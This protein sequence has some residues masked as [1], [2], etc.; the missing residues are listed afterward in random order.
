[1]KFQNVK[2]ICVVGAGAMGR[3][4][5]M[6]NALGGYDVTLNDSAGEALTKAQ[7]WAES[8]LAGRVQ[9]GRLTAEKAAEAKGKI[10]YSQD[11]T[12][13][14]SDADLVIEA[15]VELLDVKQAMFENLDAICP[16]HTIL[17]SNS[18]SYPSSQLAAFTKRPEKVCN[19][20]YFNPPTVMELVE[21]VRNEKTS[22]ETV[23]I[24]MAV[25]RQTGKGPILINKEIDGFVVNRI[26]RA[27]Y[28]EALFLL[29]N[30]YAA[31][32]DIDYAVK[33]GLNHP[34]GPFELMDQIGLDILCAKKVQ[35]YRET[36]ND[37]DRP[38][39]PLEERY[40][41][42]DLGR[43]TGKGFYDYTNK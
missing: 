13:A 17:A 37:A 23:D 30:D 21:V 15:I 33:K 20:H 22:Q 29:E 7:E 16:P 31:F 2:K 1:M 4:I 43:K 10:K 39:R 32:Q 9:K 38:A 6:V 28:T 35:K 24:V 3:Q 5:A 26:L 27:I 36:G 12:V 41:R 42:G 11:L 40:L 25:C 14:A 19:M 8:W 34:M 18:S